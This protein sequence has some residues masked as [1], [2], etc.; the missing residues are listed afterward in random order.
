[1][2]FAGLLDPAIAVS[3]G[4]IATTDGPLLDGECAAVA[5]AVPVRRAEFI[6]GRT[7]ARDAMRKLGIPPSALPR[8][9]DRTPAWPAGIIGSITHAGGHCAAA[10]A[11]RTGSL[12]SIGIDL[13]VAEDLPEDLLSSVLTPAETAELVG[14]SNAG[15]LARAIFSAKESAFKCQFNLSREMLEFEDFVVTLDIGLQ[16]FAARLTRP[17]G[18]FGR[19]H[20]FCGRMSMTERWIATTVVL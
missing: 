19:D 18:P 4:A 10:V 6:A 8:L 12:R 14:R 7:L 17:V 11:V 20:A 2:V 16:G 3:E 9:P 13:E 1:M 15:L 5:N